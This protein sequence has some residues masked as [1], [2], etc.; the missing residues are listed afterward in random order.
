MP[1]CD[2][3]YAL[4]EQMQLSTQPLDYYVFG[5]GKKPS[6]DLVFDDY[7][8]DRYRPYKVKLGLDNNYT[9]YSWKHTRVVSLIIAGFDENQIM[10]LTDHRNRAGFEAY[11]R[12]LVIDNTIM[13]GKTI[14]I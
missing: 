1:I 6:A 2:E 7:F 13:K 3:L 10:T 14:D 4:I 5:H 12:N 8:R 9:L 11:K